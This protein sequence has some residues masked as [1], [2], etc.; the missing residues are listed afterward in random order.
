[1]GCNGVETGERGPFWGSGDLKTGMFGPKMAQKGNLWSIKGQV[2]LEKYQQKAIC[3]QG[4]V[5]GWVGLTPAI[6]GLN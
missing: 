6:W 5:R 1:M 4:V 3:G 2:V